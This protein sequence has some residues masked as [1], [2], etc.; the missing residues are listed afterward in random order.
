[1]PICNA[2]VECKRDIITYIK[3]YF[4]LTKP[5][6][7]FGN[8]ITLVAGFH[9]ASKGIF[10]FWL[11]I[12]TLLGL[13]L[14][15]A[16]ACVLNNIIDRHV[17]KQMARTQKR[18]LASGVI[19]STN[20]AIFALI[21]GI[22]GALVLLLYTNLIT[23]FIA[24]V[25]FFVYICLYSFLKY[26]SSYGTLIG[27]IAGAAPPLVG[28]CAV[29]NHF[30]LAAFIL[31]MIVALWQMPH[32]YAIAIYRLNDYAALSIPVLPVKKGLQTT[33]I[34]M[35]LYIIAFI[36]ATV[37]LTFCGFAGILYLVVAAL[38]GCYWLFL[39]IK[40]F[41]SENATLWARKMFLASLVIITVLSITITVG[42]RQDERGLLSSAEKVQIDLLTDQRS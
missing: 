6:I 20:A 39:C 31:F 16:S 21:L 12:E 36:L 10:N 3:A 22:V 15:I 32:F 38:L 8:A 1:M 24:L 34:H 5:G 23:L 17:D 40:G 35:L 18:A 28:Y 7:I 19:S 33:K 11:F 2:K 13:S 29:S 41:K 42:S 14:I 37:M 30:D 26:R 25:G 27:S 4:S 9:L